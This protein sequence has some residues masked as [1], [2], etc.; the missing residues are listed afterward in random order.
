[1]AVG[2]VAKSEKRKRALLSAMIASPI[3]PSFFIVRR[4]NNENEKYS[5]SV[6]KNTTNKHARRQQQHR[7]AAAAAASIAAILATTTILTLAQHYLKI[8]KNN[9]RSKIK[10]TLRKCVYCVP[11]ESHNVGSGYSSDT[12]HT[13]ALKLKLTLT[14][15]RIAHTRAAMLVQQTRN[16]IARACDVHK[17]IGECNVGRWWWWR[18]RRRRQNDTR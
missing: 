18:R 4:H 13:H 11:T 12:A 15:V 8:D 16:L 14:H 1:M 3:Y 2:S 6:E 17:L 9:E 10:T 7:S 5:T